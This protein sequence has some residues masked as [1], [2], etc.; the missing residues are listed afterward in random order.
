MSK[1][2]NTLLAEAKRG[3]VNFRADASNVSEYWKNVQD[4][5][6]YPVSIQDAYWKDE[7]YDFHNA[8]G[9]T[10]TGRDKD[11]MLVV[12]D[13]LRNDNRQVISTVTGRYG[14]VDTSNMY[15]FLEE[16]LV[17]AKIDHEPVRLW[18]SG[19]GG[20]QQL[21]VHIKDQIGMNGLPDELRMY[22]RMDTSVDGTTAHTLRTIIN[23]KDTDTNYEM[24][25]AQIDL[26][27][28]H[29]NTIDERSVHFIPF[30]NNMMKNWNDLIIPTM[31]LMF[32]AKYDRDMALELL[33]ETCKKAKMGK[34]HM[35]RIVELYCSGGV[36]TNDTSDSLYRINH[37]I[38]EYIDDELSDDKAETAERFKSLIA[39][40]MQNE[41]DKLRRKGKN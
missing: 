29:T 23:N 13:M 28:R 19:N 5:V 36:R 17:S 32:N 1:N 31:S 8:S 16:E 21:H 12:V 14:T 26:S 34:R 40:N 2:F 25:D 15:R 18:V 30:I 27:A 7:K 3:L 38:N 10:G 9:Q 37:T 6:D 11:F 24:K 4:A 41:I 20:R 33:E 39:K 35:N 22:I